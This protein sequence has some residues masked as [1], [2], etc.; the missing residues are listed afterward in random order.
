MKLTTV[1]PFNFLAQYSGYTYLEEPNTGIRVRQFKD[2]I[3][4][5]CSVSPNALGQLIV[6]TNAELQNDGLISGLYSKF[7]NRL[8]YPI[9]TMNGAVWRVIEG[10]PLVDSFGR[11]NRFRYRCL[12]ITPPQGSVTDAPTDQ[13]DAIFGN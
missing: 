7:E 9:G 11:Y 4:I 6:Y 12:M 2:P 3:E 13:I 10:Q 5:K 8:L 1:N